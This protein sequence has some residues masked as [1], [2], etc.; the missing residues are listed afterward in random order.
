VKYD[1]GGDRHHQGKLRRSAVAAAL[2]GTTLRSAVAAA[3]VGTTLRA[4]VAAALL[5][6]T[7][8]AATACGGAHSA[9]PKA[10]SGQLTAQDVDTF[11]NCMRSH[12]LPNFY[13][14]RASSQGAGSANQ[15]LQ[16]GPWIFPVTDPGSP[17]FTAALSACR[18]LVG[19]PSGPPP[20]LT[21]AQ[22]HS[23]VRAAECMRAHGFP[24]YPDPDIEDGHLIR[25]APPSS[26]DTSSPQFEAAQQT[27]HA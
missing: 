27:C 25:Q 14:S 11:A 7:L 23:L 9:A 15:V 20:T 5:G 26:I 12:G 8:L 3:L 6:T 24:S 19:L 1:S 18:H 2:V 4:A 21:A 13:P 22:I 16:L 10:S 17:Q